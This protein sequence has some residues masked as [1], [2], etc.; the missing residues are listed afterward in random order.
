MA[1]V[2]LISALLLGASLVRWLRLPL[3]A[4]EAAAMTIVLGL[5]SWTWLALIF[6]L[7]LPYA[8]SVPLTLL[9]SATI[10]AALWWPL[11]HHGWSW[12]QLEG[13]RRS[14]Y[15]WGG[16]SLI[17]ALQFGRLFW[18]HMLIPEASGIYSAGSTWADFGMHASLISHFAAADRLPLDLPVASGLNLTYPF[19][20][21]LLSALY[22]RGGWDLHLALFI[23][24]LLLVWSICQLI[25]SFSL[26]L[27]QR[28]S[29]A[30]IS[31]ILILFNGA[32]A[33]LTVAWHDWQTSGLSL[34]AFLAN[35]PRDYTGL[36]ELNAH[37]SNLIANVLLPQRAALFGFGIGLIIFI[38]LHAA[39]HTGQARYRLSAAILIGLLPMAHPHTFIV[40]MVV[41]AAIAAEQWLQ[42]SNRLPWNWITAIGLALVIALPQLAW[43]QLGNNL[44]TGGHWAPGWMNQPGDSI[45]VFWWRN[46][47]IM[48]PFFLAL[49]LILL[50]RKW[51]QYLVW[52]LPMLLILII[53]QLYAF[54]PFEYDNLKLIQYVYL[55]AL[56]F[57]GRFIVQLVQDSKLNLLFIAPL[58]LSVTIP[59]YLAASR[60]F[61]LHDQFA[62]TA[63]VALAGWVKTNTAP[64]DVFITTDR[65]NQPI[66][67]LGGRPIV[68]GYRGWLYSYHLPYQ[69]RQEAVTLALAGNVTDPTV[70]QFHARYLAIG[71]YEDQSWVI[72]RTKLSSLPIA[73]QN[74]AWTVYRLP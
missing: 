60:E 23:P 64:S 48:G 46:F 21:N 7:T 2:L 55:I 26:R 68:M 12:R 10:T 63:D 11:R 69:D 73:Y 61:Q 59:G 52:Y 50:Q 42:H 45:F 49:P 53:T 71:I 3:Y 24:G 27:F 34:S 18:T 51:R 28:F 1:L 62:S 65:P 9:T 70:R 15:I 25:L 36:D 56:L 35:I 8:W 58:I 14:W 6:A 39:R 43:Q 38:L 44:G 17:L 67:T 57:A 37:V 30:V 66:A 29:A 16:L 41:L 20:I 22:V 5:F 13:G 72:D 40:M 19:L 4:F 32:A 33:G 47:G 74:A 54:Q 31:L